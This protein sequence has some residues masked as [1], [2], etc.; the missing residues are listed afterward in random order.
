MVANGDAETAQK[1]KN[2]KRERFN[3]KLHSKQH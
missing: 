3:N 2:K 1:E